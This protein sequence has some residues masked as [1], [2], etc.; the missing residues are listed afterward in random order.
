MQVIV[1]CGPPASGKTTYVREHMRV[2]DLVVDL[3][4]IMQAISFQTHRSPETENLLPVA[5]ELRKYVYRII[6][7]SRVHAYRC[8]II[9]CL[10]CEEEREAM[11]ERFNAEIIEMQTSYGECIRRALQDPNRLDK[12][13]QYR[14]IEKHFWRKNHEERE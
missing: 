10:P 14:A 8:W 7:E 9:E 1:V 4:A 12:K 6:D 3:D 5:L 2:G 13:E 11:Q